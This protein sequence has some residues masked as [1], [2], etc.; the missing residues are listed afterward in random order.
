MEFAGPFRG[1]K[2]VSSKSAGSAVTGCRS[3]ERL[4]APVAEIRDVKLQPLALAPAKTGRACIRKSPTRSSPSWRRAACPGF[5]PGERRRRRRRSPCRRMQ[6]RA[7][8]LGHQ[9]ADSL[10]RGRSSAASPARVGSPSARPS[11]SA[12]MSARVSMARPSSML[13][14]SFRMTNASEPKRRTRAQDDPVPQTLHRLQHGPMRR[15]S[16]MEAR[17]PRPRRCP[18]V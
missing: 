9:C 15:P 4:A 18:R 3:R 7:P 8:I 14:A 1:G 10:G 11:A 17:Q 5:S 6:H 2:L 16:S 12:A 13:T